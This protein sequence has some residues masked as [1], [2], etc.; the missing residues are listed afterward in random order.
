VAYPSLV[1]VLV[2]HFFFILVLILVPFLLQKQRFLHETALS[3]IFVAILSRNERV[4]GQS[5]FKWNVFTHLKY[6]K[7]NFEKQ[8]RNLHLRTLGMHGKK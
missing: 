7:K 8:D 6:F 3:V 5:K 2:S 4:F 1:L